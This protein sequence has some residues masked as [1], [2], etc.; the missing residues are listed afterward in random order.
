MRQ[1]ISHYCQELFIGRMFA[2]SS[3]VG[4]GG[5]ICGCSSYSGRFCDV[6]ARVGTFGIGS[7]QS[8]L[9]LGIFVLAFGVSTICTK[10]PGR[11]IVAS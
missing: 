6:F 3:R 10:A 5:E 11:E 1:E 8:F 4:Y 9:A 7:F 2:Q